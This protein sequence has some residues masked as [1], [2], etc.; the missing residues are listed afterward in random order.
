MQDTSGGKAIGVPLL[1]EPR[2]LGDMLDLSVQR[3]GSRNVLDFMLDDLLKARQSEAIAAAE[4]DPSALERYR[5][6]EKRRLELRQRLKPA[7]GGM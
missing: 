7:T 4:T 5:A 3:F 6:L 2:L 1:G